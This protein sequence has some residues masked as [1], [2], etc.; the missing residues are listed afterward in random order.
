MSVT[1]RDIAE[2]CG[3]SEGTVDRALNNRAGIKTSTKE[4]ILRVAKELDYKPNHMASC[5]AKGNT[6][7]IGVV[8]A[9]MQNPFF[10]AL[11]EAIERIAYENGY[12][13]TLV[14][15]HN[16]MEKEREGITYLAE[17]Q[18]DGLIIM[19]LGHGAE[20]E[21]WLAGLDIP[22]VT[23]YNRISDKFVHIDVDGREIMEEAVA[24]LVQKGYKRVAYL[25][26][27]YD[28]ECIRSHNRY[29]LNKRRQGYMDGVE[30]EQ[31]GLP[32]VMTT[33]DWEPI[34]NFIREEGG[35]P[36]ILCPF[37]TVAIRVMNL[38]RDHEVRVPEDVGVMGFDNIPILESI[39]PRL[40][41]VDCNIYELGRKAFEV[42]LQLIKNDANVSDYTVAYTFT[43]GKSL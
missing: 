6:K 30:K 29:S 22:I 41:S 37:D 38:L 16:D 1:I 19:P 39:S 11:I 43:E 21:A 35:K 17:R 8:C 40:C 36:A 10:T 32:T 7:T 23:V 18:V 13:L 15:N 14:L 4:L 20:Y 27:G 26:H 9:G 42:L 34:A 12:Y 5:L 2:K 31:L 33:F 25:D 28:M 3:V 24:R